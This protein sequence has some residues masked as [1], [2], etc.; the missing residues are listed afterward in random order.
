MKKTE[1]CCRYKPLVVMSIIFF[2]FAANS[3]KY[4]IYPLLTHHHLS[5]APLFSPDTEGL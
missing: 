2:L 1:L 5:R 3:I 4:H